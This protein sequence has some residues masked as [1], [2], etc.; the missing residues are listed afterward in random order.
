MHPFFKGFVFAFQGMRT[1][2]KEERNA[3]FH[4]FVTLLLLPLACYYPISQVEWLF[5]ILCIGLVF[6][7]EAFNSAL[8][9]LAN[10]IQADYDPLIGQ[11]KDLAAAAVLILS[12][13]SAAIGLIIFTPHLLHTL[14]L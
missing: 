8:E 13:A 6:S 12:I 3:R 9:R 4:A 7:A 10:R 2:L 11:A 5:V 1:L 14:G